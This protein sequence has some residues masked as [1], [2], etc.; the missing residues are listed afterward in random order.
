MGAT[1]AIMARVFVAYQPA[2][3]QNRSFW[4]KIPYS[5]PHRPMAVFSVFQ[6][7]LAQFGIPKAMRPMAIAAV[8]FWGVCVLFTLQRYFNFYPTYVA[9]DQGIFNQVFWNTMHGRLFEGSLSST[10]SINVLVDGEAPDVA[11]RRLGQHFTPALLLWVPYYAL[12]RSP[13]GLSVLQITLVTAAGFVLYALARHYHPPILANLIAI[14]FFAANAV[15][16]P[17]VANFHDL[18]QLPLYLFGAFW[19]LEKRRW[20]LF[21][22]LISLTLLVRE[23]TGIVLFG[24]GLYLLLSRRFPKV[25]AGVC[26]LSV[27]YIVL[28]TNVVMPLFSEDISRRFMVEQFGHFLDQPEASTLEVLWA[29]ASQPF[30]LL[31]ELV[32][33]LDRTLNYILGQWLPLAFVPALSPSAWVMIAFPLTKTLMRQDPTALSLHLRYALTLVPGLFYGAILWWAAHPLWFQPKIRKFW[34]FCIGLAILLTLTSNPNRAFSIIIPDSF[35]PWVYAAP[36]TQWHHAQAV[37]GL[38][39]Q[40]PSDASVSATSYLIAHLSN[41]REAVRYPGIRIRGDDD[42]VRIVEYQLLDFWYPRL[43]SAAFDDERQTLRNM[44]R[45]LNEWLERERYGLI[46]FQDGV[47]LLQ[48]NVPST[49]SALEAWERFQT[50]PDGV[51]PARED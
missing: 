14:S 35:Q 33:P 47:A 31:Q 51:L 30:L 43:F 44:T 17:T 20:P 4:Y 49:P 7:N 42:E 19:A 25:G 18:S 3:S 39:T 24:I 15:I 27:G 48:H 21:W 50:T 26:L 8:I 29:I 28:V 38:M 6:K 41:R 16:A 36:S 13:I 10:E 11:Y 5:L 32:T 9:F 22:G 40:I 45:R 46:D 34:Q 12:V 37:R 1:H 2:G 23:D